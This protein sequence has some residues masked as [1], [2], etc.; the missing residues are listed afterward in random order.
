MI[1]MILERIGF[2]SLLSTIHTIMTL[3]AVPGDADTN[4][5]ITRSYVYRNMFF[6]GYISRDNV[7]KSCTGWSF[8]LQATNFFQAMG[9]TFYAASQLG[10]IGITIKKGK[11]A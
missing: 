8:P 10:A 7:I 3:A 11:S 6:L 1:W 5:R 9:I 2:Q 4:Y